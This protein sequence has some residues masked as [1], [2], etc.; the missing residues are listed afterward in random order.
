M[1]TNK[2]EYNGQNSQIFKARPAKSQDNVELGGSWASA[3]G[4]SA[5]TQPGKCHDGQTGCL[6]CVQEGHFIRVCPKNKQGGGNMGKIAQ[7]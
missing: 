3:C 4:R 6:K 2:V 1:P 5:T 7:T